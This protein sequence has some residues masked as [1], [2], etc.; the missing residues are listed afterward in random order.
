MSGADVF[1]KQVVVFMR[2]FDLAFEDAAVCVVAWPQEILHVECGFL[3][4]RQ[5]GKAA[6]VDPVDTDG[7][8]GR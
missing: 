5:F 1:R 7:I 6:V 8:T 4:R 3:F 2:A